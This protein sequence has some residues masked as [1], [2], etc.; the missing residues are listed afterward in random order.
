MSREQRYN[1]ARRGV[2]GVMYLYPRPCRRGRPGRK[3]EAPCTFR[4]VCYQLV[5]DQQ[6]SRFKPAARAHLIESELRAGA[7]A[8]RALSLPLRGRARRALSLDVVLVTS[9]LRMFCGLLALRRKLTAPHM[10]RTSGALVGALSA[11]MVCAEGAC[12]AVRA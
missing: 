7:G 8:V 11:N 4:G 10:I 1:A 3:R 2:V 9:A 6:R 5:A 12:L